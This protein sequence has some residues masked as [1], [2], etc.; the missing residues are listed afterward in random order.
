MRRKRIL[1]YSPILKII[2][3]YKVGAVRELQLAT[4]WIETPANNSMKHDV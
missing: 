2:N 3:I 4:Y 1:F